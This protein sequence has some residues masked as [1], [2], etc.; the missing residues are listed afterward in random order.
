MG[1]DVRVS[2]PVREHR[3]RRVGPAHRSKRDGASNSQ[4]F[5]RL[6]TVRS[7]IA[8]PSKNI[9]NREPLHQE[10]RWIN[11]YFLTAKYR[12]NLTDDGFVGNAHPTRLT[13]IRFW[14]MG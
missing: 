3:R 6:P 5:H 12:Y 9:R 4:H 14:Y 1:E 8:N 10:N 2:T 13:F 7:A 11:F